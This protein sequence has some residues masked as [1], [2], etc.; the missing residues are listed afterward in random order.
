MLE[1]CNISKGIAKYFEAKF[2]FYK[3][4]NLE[5]FIIQKRDFLKLK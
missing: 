1:V 2:I 4:L 3:F 5:S